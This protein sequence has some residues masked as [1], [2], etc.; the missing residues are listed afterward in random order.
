MLAKYVMLAETTE[1]VTFVGRLGTY[2][3]LDMDTTIHEALRTAH[4]FL[5]LKLAFKAMPTFLVSPLEK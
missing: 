1:G 4:A 2:S 3:Y 5:S